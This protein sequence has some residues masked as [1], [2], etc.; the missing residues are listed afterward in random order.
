[1]IYLLIVLGIIAII[2]KVLDIMLK[3]MIDD[4]S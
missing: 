4:G 1:M 2:Y 3:K